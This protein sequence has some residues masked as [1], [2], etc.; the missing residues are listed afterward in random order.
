MAKK[1]EIAHLDGNRSNN[2][3]DNLAQATDQAHRH[4]KLVCYA[5]WLTVH[6]AVTLAAAGSLCQGCT[7]SIINL[8]LRVKCPPV[9][10][11]RLPRA[12]QLFMIVVLHPRAL[13][14]EVTGSKT[15]VWRAA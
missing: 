5:M 14:C 8:L 1:D 9:A 10:F 7:D 3:I 12:V 4:A 13:R 11:P 6:E 15:N 2:L